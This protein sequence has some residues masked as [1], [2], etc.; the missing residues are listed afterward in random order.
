MSEANLD[1][2]VDRGELPR[3]PRKA[4]IK[5]ALPELF[6]RIHAGTWQ[7]SEEDDL[8]LFRRALELSP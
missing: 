1:W 2:L 8:W 3:R 7:G 4:A 5:A 6:A